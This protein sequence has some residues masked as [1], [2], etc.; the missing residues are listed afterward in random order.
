MSRGT[1]GRNS[2]GDRDVDCILMDDSVPTIRYQSRRTYTGSSRPPRGGF[3]ENIL[4]LH[5]PQCAEYCYGRPEFDSHKYTFQR[6]HGHCRFLSP[7]Y[8]RWTQYE[9]LGK[10][11]REQR[12][13]S[14]YRGRELD[15][16]DRDPD[17]SFQEYYGRRRHYSTRYDDFIGSQHSQGNPIIFHDRRYTSNQH[18][19]SGWQARSLLQSNSRQRKGVTA[20]E[21]AEKRR[22]VELDKNGKPRGK[23]GGLSET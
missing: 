5:S 4:G 11:Y 16:R 13:E 7:E 17:Y 9:V 10:E 19:S 23:N 3:P 2:E 22:Y 20:K 8:G 15:Y 12:R 18:G 6:T 1:D 14:A 21:E